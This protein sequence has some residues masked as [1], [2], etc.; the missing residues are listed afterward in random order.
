MDDLKLHI[1]GILNRFFGPP[2]VPVFDRWEYIS[3][4]DGRT[5]RALVRQFP[6][7]IGRILKTEEV[8]SV[9]KSERWESSAG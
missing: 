8:E 4:K 5:T 6:S 9:W 7:G 2:L 3:D 1:A